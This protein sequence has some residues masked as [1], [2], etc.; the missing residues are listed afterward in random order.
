MLKKARQGKHES[1]PTIPARWYASETYKTSLSLIGCKEKRT[2]LYDRVALEKHSCTATKSERIQ[3]SKRCM[4]TLNKEGPQQPLNQRPDFAQAKR[5][6]KRLHDEHM[7][8]TQQDY[9]TIPRSQ[10]VRQRK[11]QAFEGLE[12]YDYA[13]D[14]QTGWRFSKESRGKLGSTHWKTSS[15]S[16]Q[17][18]ARHATCHVSFFLPDL[19]PATSTSSL[20]LIS[21][22]SP[23][24]PTISP[25]HTRP[26]V[27]DPYLPCDVPRQSGGSTQI[28]SLTGYEPK[29]IET[30][31]IEPEDLGPRRIEFDRNLGTDPSQIQERCMRNNYHNP[32]TEDMDELGEV[33]VKMSFIES[34]MH[35]DYDSAESVADSDLEGGELRKMLAS[36]LYMKSRGIANP[37]ECQSH[38]GNL[39]HFYR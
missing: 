34:Q 6:C 5:E 26:L 4:L 30:E 25:I 22:T 21:S 20:S 24:F 3:D 36:P 15:W 37:L 35:S 23:I 29:A 13:V 11:G 18:S 28:P 16:S 14:P 17:H 33:G 2:M 9:R 38:Q 10:Q 8:R 39:L 7:A 12:E 32:I 1:H 27:H 31:A 19:T